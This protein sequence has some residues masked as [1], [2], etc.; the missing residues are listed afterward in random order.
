MSRFI[1]FSVNLLL[2]G[3]IA[4]TSVTMFQERGRARD[5]VSDRSSWVGRARPPA[6]FNPESARRC[7]QARESSERTWRVA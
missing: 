7:E 2:A 3:V 1:A 5:V 6:R 4:L